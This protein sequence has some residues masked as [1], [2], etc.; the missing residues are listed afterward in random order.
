MPLYNP[1]IQLTE[2]GGGDRSA[3]GRRGRFLGSRAA[4][5]SGEHF[6]GRSQLE[7]PVLFSG[8][9]ALRS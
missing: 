3:S 6:V 1:A 8:I 5:Q 2:G 4:A 9:E 7:A